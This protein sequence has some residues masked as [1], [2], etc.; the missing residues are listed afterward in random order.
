MMLR[1]S[2]VALLTSL[3]LNAQSQTG[4]LDFRVITTGNAP[5]AGASVTLEGPDGRTHSG[6]TERDGHLRLTN[7]APGVYEFTAF[8]APGYVRNPRNFLADV[9]IHE[10]HTRE[11]QFELQ[12][13]PKL[14]G[15]LVDEQGNPIAG[16]AVLAYTPRVGTLAG[17]ARTDANGFYSM[18]LNASP[19]SFLSTSGLPVLVLAGLIRRDAPEV[20]V[21]RPAAAGAP[22]TIEF[23]LPSLPLSLFETVNLHLRPA[24]TA[25]R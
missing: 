21:P 3:A 10:G 14:Q 12:P 24:L 23:E 5:V 6:A 18:T 25:I 9:F 16:A 8:S 15:T 19:D 11:F 1:L 17:E 13:A 20:W 7:L 4:S 22:L 2:V